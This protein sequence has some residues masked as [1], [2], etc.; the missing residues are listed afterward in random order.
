MNVD[1]PF[2]ETP[3]LNYIKFFFLFSF[4]T[5]CFRNWNHLSM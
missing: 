3:E 5:E 2:Y 4:F 1:E